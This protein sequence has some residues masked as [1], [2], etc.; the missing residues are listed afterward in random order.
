MAGYIMTLGADINSE[1]FKSLDGPNT[2]K[3]I[4]AKEKSLEDCV[5]YG[6]YST[7]IALKSNTKIAT[8]ADYFGMRKGDNIY[9]FYNRCIYGIGKI[10]DI[11]GVCCFYNPSEEALYDGF[12][13]VENQP[14]ICI[15]E[16]SPFFFKEGVDM[17]DVLLSNPKAFKRLRFFHQRSFIQ[18]DDTE[19]AA[20][21][22]FIIQKHEDSLTDYDSK[23]HF[24]SSEVQTTHSKIKNKFNTNPEL[25]SLKAINVYPEGVKVQRYPDKI[26]SEYYVEGLILD[27]VKTQNRLLGYW[28][29]MSRQ[30]P[31]SPSKPAEYA[32]YMDIFG[33][34]YVKGY[35]SERIISKFIIIEL[36]SDQANKGAVLQIMKYVDWVCREFAH[37]DYSMI[38]AYIISYDADDVL[39]A[40]TSLYTRNYIK[41]IHHNNRKEIEFYEDHW[42]NLK[43]ISYLDILND[44][45]NGS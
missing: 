9:F 24:D 30:Y 32:E 15:F 2:I 26:S 18:L 23:K 39:L 43:Y 29:F 17:D 7:S 1:F 25:Y 4:L 27:Y 40:D 12:S 34:K 38:E 42:N 31:A 8:R 28:D 10:I 44:I 41:N 45:K 14:F 6:I 3:E 5:L 21:K 37:N 19:N 22:S 13:N 20:L 36:K 33:Y 16:P 35:E 11:N